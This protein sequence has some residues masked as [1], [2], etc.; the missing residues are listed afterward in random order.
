MLRSKPVQAG[1]GERK[2]AFL[3]WTPKLI[4]SKELVFRNP[5]KPL[6]NPRAYLNAGDAGVSPPLGAIAE[7]W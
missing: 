3:S 4:E 1:F 2:V 6:E 7:S 5:K